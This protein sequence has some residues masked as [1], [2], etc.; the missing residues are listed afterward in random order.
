MKLALAAQSN[1]YPAAANNMTVVL[2]CNVDLQPST[3]ITLRGFNG[4]QSGAALQLRSADG[5]AVASQLSSEAVWQAVQ[6][7]V[8]LNV[9]TTLPAHTRVGV[10]FELI[11]PSAGRPAARLHAESV[12]AGIAPRVIV[13][14]QE[15]ILC[16]VPT[17]F[18]GEARPLTI[19]DPLL[20]IKEA[21]QSSTFPGKLDNIITVSLQSNAQLS[22]C[23]LTITGLPASVGNSSQAL[24][25]QNLGSEGSSEVFSTSAGVSQARLEAGDILLNVP[26]TRAMRPYYTYAFSFTLRNPSSAQAAP[27][28]SIS[29]CGIIPTPQPMSSPSGPI[30]GLLG[31]VDG[32]AHVLKVHR[33]R[34][35]YKLIVQSNAWPDS[36]ST[37][38]I[39]LA[40]NVA[41]ASPTGCT[42]ETCTRIVI[43]GLV[44][45]QTQDNASLPVQLAGASPFASVAVWS[46]SQGRLTMTINPGEELPAGVNATISFVLLNAVSLR[47]AALPTIEAKLSDASTIDAAAMDRHSTRKLPMLGSVAGDMLPLKV[48]N[49][50]FVLAQAGQTSAYPADPTNVI[51]VTVACNVNLAS[52]STITLK[53]LSSLAAGSITLD[54]SSGDFALD[55]MAS[56]EP[57]S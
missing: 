3:G 49:P 18:R 56:I 12:E 39:S 9:S 25:L 7:T 22:D 21:S 37:L 48:Y 2:E 14:D 57:D 28:L 17:T 20:T 15:L 50:A 5:T 8:R 29:A 10:M 26:A 41:L 31:S 51:T 35:I 38:T 11:N 46:Q 40:A 43:N 47:Q 24:T 32:D 13:G 54:G 1:P 45:T 53:G 4:S 27:A 19:R 6:Q 16:G 44:G 36:V 55:G 34:F 30:P 33:P 52:Q 23:S 42:G